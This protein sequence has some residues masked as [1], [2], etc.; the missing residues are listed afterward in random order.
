MNSVVRDGDTLL[1]GG[2][3]DALTAVDL[4]A[5]LHKP[6]TR[7]RH[8]LVDLAG[9]TFLGMGGVRVLSA[10]RHRAARTSRSFQV[11]SRSR[12]EPDLHP[13]RRV[14]PR[15]GQDGGASG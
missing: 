3:I 9:V 7:S 1:V 8:V 4:G 13:A 5:A 14:G 12:R 10:A 15:T 6:L 2:E 11:I